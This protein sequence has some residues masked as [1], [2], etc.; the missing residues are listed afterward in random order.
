MS[1]GVRYPGRHGDAACHHWRQRR[2]AMGNTPEEESVQL[3]GS[4]GR[5]EVPGERP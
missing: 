2:A 4:E 1:R 5:A 3:A